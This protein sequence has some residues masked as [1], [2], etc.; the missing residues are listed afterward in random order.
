MHM[1][2]TRFEPTNETAAE[3]VSYCRDL[4]GVEAEHGNLDVMGVYEKQRRPKKDP[5]GLNHQQTAKR[6]KRKRGRNEFEEKQ[7]TPCPI[8]PN[9]KHSMEDCRALKK[10]REESQAKYEKTSKFTRN[11][12]SHSSR[13]NQTSEEE[14]NVMVEQYLTKRLFPKNH[15]GYKCRPRRS[16]KWRNPLTKEIR[17]TVV[18]DSQ[19]TDSTDITSSMTSS[20]ETA[21][22]DPSTS[23]SHGETNKTIEEELKEFSEFTISDNDKTDDDIVLGELENPGDIDKQD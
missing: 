15:V 2:L 14:V 11:K 17:T 19:S 16:I 22:D 3:I 21:N 12:N 13:S 5:P 1:K 7:F 6:R 20:V 10:L 8:H 4:E 23:K 9:G 18:P